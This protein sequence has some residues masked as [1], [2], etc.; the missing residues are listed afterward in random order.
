MKLHSNQLL[1]HLGKPLLP[2]YLVSGDEPLLVMEACDQIRAAARQQG[3]EERQLFHAEAGFDWSQLRDEAD[4]MSLFAS[5]RIL[6]IRIP[7]GKPSDKGDTLKALLQRPNPDNLLLIIC[8]RLDSKSQNTAWHKAVDKHGA[9]VQIW[10][11][12]RNQY[13]GWLRHRLQQAGLQADPTAIALLAHQTEGNLLAAVQ[14]IEKLRMSGASRITEDLLLDALGDNAR[15]TAFGF[16]DACLDGSV[17]DASRIL[18]HLR[19][20]GVEVLSILGALTH[21]IRQLLTLSGKTGQALAEA[22]KQARVWPRQQGSYKTALSRLTR[23]ELQ[24]A[25]II[26]AKVDAAAKGQ[27][28]N[29]WL[30][31]SELTLLVT[32]T[33]LFCPPR[34]GQS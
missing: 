13:A 31:M 4:A 2:V 23:Q 29:A 12:E 1:A 22:F 30:L 28:G 34:L 11:I 19:A 3:F 5:R 27:G 14:E 25:L 7:N 10:P 9:L 16:A 24:Q 8:P 17:Q 15:F 6:E 32:S 26:A 20:E 33:Q 18:S 21:K